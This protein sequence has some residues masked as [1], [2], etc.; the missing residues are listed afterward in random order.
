[1]FCLKREQSRLTKIL[2][3]FTDKKISVTIPHHIELQAIIG[4]VV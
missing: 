1:M 3:L 4:E 2:Y